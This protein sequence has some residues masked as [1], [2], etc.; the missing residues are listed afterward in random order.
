MRASAF[1][2]KKDL[3]WAFVFYQQN[4]VGIK[5]NLHTVSTVDCLVIAK[6]F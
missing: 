6:A 4:V 1:K 2:V 3:P 5:L